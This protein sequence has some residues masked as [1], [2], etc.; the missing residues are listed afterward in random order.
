MR[1]RILS[2]GP[3]HV[4]HS[5]N[6]PSK[7]TQ[8]AKRNSTDSDK[9][10]ARRLMTILLLHSGKTIVE[11]NEITGAARSSIG[12]WLNW[13]TEDGMETL[14]SFPHKQTQRLPVWEMQA[15]LLLLIQ[16]S[17]QDFDYQRSRWSTELL[18]DQVNTLFQSTVAAS[19][20]RRW[21]PK[22]SI[23]WRRAGPVSH[24]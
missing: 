24:L 17:P 2:V 13:F 5:I 23:V 12:R 20:V 10:Y 21:L 19:T 3:S 4:Y 14:A 15:M 9:G 22:I 8:N 6:T 16:F 18:V 1:T 11:A 7:T